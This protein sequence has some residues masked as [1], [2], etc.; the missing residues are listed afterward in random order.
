MELM[1]STMAELCMILSNWVDIP[2]MLTPLSGDVA[3][4]QGLWFK[5]LE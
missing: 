1:F 5:E 3:P 2:A 4:P